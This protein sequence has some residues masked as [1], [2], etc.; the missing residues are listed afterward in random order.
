MNMQEIKRKIIS[1]VLIMP[2]TWLA[3]ARE[4]FAMG[5]HPQ[6]PKLSEQQNRFKNIGLVLVVDA[7]EGTEMLGNEF[8][9]D[10][11]DRRFYASSVTRLGNRS[12]MAFPSGIVP[13]KVRVIWRDSDKIVGRADNPAVNTYAGKVLGDYTISIA[14]R[15]PDEVVKEIRANGGGLRLKFRLKPDGVLFGWDIERFSGG[16]PRH[17][18]PGGDFR[19]AGL[20]YELPGGIVYMAFLNP[21]TASATPNPAVKP[22]LDSGEYFVPHR[23]GDVWRKGWY[24]DQDG[25]KILTEY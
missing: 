22:Y 1:T 14:S 19:E 24:M 2:F 3:A 17:S 18:M 12:S 8:F 15:I 20:A 11:A 7:V 25:R 6:K 23:S 4:A 5:Q 10:G 16:L 9:A 13:E 21:Y